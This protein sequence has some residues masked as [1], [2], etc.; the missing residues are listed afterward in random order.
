YQFVQKP[1]PLGLQ[2]DIKKV[3]ACQILIGTSH[4]VD[5][6]SLDGVAASQENDRNRLGCCLGGERRWWAASGDDYVDSLTHQFGSQ[7]GQPI[8]F[9]LSPTI[10]NRNIFAVNK[11][12]LLQPT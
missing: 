5:E 12:G 2:L 9:L 1:E 4:T 11:P 8:I 7:G 6:A 10:H 3:D